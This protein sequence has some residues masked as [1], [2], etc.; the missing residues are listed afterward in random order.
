MATAMANSG[1]RSA[2]AR[3]R[4]QIGRVHLQGAPGRE[5]WLALRVL[6]GLTGLLQTVLLALGG[7]GVTGE[8]AGLLE[9]GAVIGV[10][11]DERTGDR[12]A[13]AAGLAG[14]AAAT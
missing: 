5:A 2:L 14:G 1:V 9:R 6:R 4:T 8:E 7:A 12:E 13:Q 3:P 10:V 11:L